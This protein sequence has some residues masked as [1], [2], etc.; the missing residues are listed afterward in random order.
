MF[1]CIIGAAASGKTTTLEYLVQRHGFQRLYFSSHQPSVASASYFTTIKALSEFVTANWKGNF[2]TC[3]VVCP[4]DLKLLRKRPFVLLVAVDA[5][6]TVRYQRLK[7]RLDASG[8]AP[9]P[10][11]EDFL[12]R[13]DQERYH[14]GVDLAGTEVHISDTCSV[15][16][17]KRMATAD[18]YVVNSYTTIEAY[19]AYLDKVHLTNPERLRPAWDTYFMLLSELASHRSNCMKRRVGCILTKD[20]RVIATGYNGT[21]RGISNCADGGCRRCN[22]GAHCGEGLDLCL[23]LHAEENAL[24]EAGR[25]RVESVGRTI[26]YC[27]TCPCLGCA[28]KI[29][30]VGVQEVVYSQAYGMDKLTAALFQ[31]AGV[32]LRQHTP[33]TLKLDIQGN[34][35][36]FM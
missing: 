1:A 17:Y 35:N 32:L 8:A 9:V 12:L 36:I 16:L 26:L 24:L 31:E 33:P 5:P 25:V 23:C 4:N 2:V 34:V 28:K 3:D 7:Q 20:N 27:N 18:V 22:S 30:Q 10:S 21:P 6:I 15:P 29:A 11:L 14:A 19:Y 13:H